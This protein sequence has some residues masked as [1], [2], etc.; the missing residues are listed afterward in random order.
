MVEIMLCYKGKEIKDFC[1]GEQKMKDIFSRFV[2]KAQTSIEKI[3][4]I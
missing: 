1:G 3:F 4:F 2:N